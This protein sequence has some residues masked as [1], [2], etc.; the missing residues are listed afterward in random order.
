MELNGAVFSQNRHRWNTE[1]TRIT[2][3]LKHLKV[4]TCWR[5][6]PAPPGRRRSQYQVPPAVEVV[7]PVDLQSAK[8][9]KE[10]AVVMM[11]GS[12]DP[13]LHLQDGGLDQVLHGDLVTAGHKADSRRWEIELTSNNSEKKLFNDASPVII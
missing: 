7:P 11:M 3:K 4:F 13:L 1:I 8:G 2:L 12:Y 6:T 10:G 9:P 5:R